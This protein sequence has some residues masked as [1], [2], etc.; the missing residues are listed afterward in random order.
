MSDVDAYN[1][2]EYFDLTIVG[3]LVYV[4]ENYEVDTLVLWQHDDGRLFYAQSAVVGPAFEWAT[5]LD[6]LDTVRRTTFGVFEEAV[7]VHPAD[8]TQRYALIQKALA[9]IAVE[10]RAATEAMAADVGEEEEAA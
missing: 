3:E 8:A 1:Q 7:S 4:D 6:Q 5:S 9:Y 10:E 2:P